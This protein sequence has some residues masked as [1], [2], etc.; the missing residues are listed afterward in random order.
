MNWKRFLAIFLTLCMLFSFAAYGEQAYYEEEEEEETEQTDPTG[1]GE[2]PT[3]PTDPGN[4]S[5]E[6]QD[7]NGP[8]VA[9]ATATPL[10][11]KVTDQNGN[12]AWLFGSIHAGAEYFYPLPEYVTSAYEGADALAVE[13]D[14][15]AFE[16][17]M[18]EQ[19]AIAG[20]MLYTDG[21]T[22]KDYISTE[23]YDE[24]VK[25]LQENNMHFPY[26]DIYHV[27]M[28]TDTIN[29][30]T[31]EKT[32]V[33]YDLGVDMH[34]LNCAYR[35]NKKIIDV[36]SAAFQF[37]MLLGFSAGLQELLL[38][39]AIA[40]YYA[41]EE[42]KASLNEM[43]A[44]WATGNESQFWAYLD[45]E[46]T[47]ATP[48]EKALY[49]EYTKAMETDRNVGMADFVEDALASGEEVFVCV[50]SAHVVGQDAMVDLLRERG[51]TVTLVQ[52]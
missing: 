16:T 13:F 23:L 26:M 11:Y 20:K 45:Q 36:E 46:E 12:V 4:N 18:A 30:I 41:P 14:I 28:W 44:V 6:N 33:N 50:G 38:A 34:L 35:D 7:P 27:A 31:E 37:D 49:D 10:L 22:V 3:D 32:A 17:D 40:S 43:M 2:N 47:F 19:M 52:E 5:G 42:Y 8:I 21:S 51:Y 29:G 1:S 15:K 39:D 9:P 24:A 48:E 25:I